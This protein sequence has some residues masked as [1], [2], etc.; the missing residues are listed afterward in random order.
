MLNCVTEMVFALLRQVKLESQLSSLKLE[1]A[2]S[3]L[4]AARIAYVSS[5]L[6]TASKKRGLFDE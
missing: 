1:L 3:R 5:L 4:M 2:L 6:K